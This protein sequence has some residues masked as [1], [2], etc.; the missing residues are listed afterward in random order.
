MKSPDIQQS[1]FLLAV[2]FT[3]ASYAADKCG[4]FNLIE[5][6]P[7]NETWLNPGFYSYHF[8]YDKNL[9]NNNPGLGVEYRYSTVSSVTAGRFHNSDWQISNYA[10]WYWQPFR[11]GSMR[12]GALLGA[13]D[14]YP[15]TRDGD[16]FLMALPIA[17]YEYKNIGINLTVVPTIKDTVYGSLTLQLKLK[18]H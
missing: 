10:A 6:K 14:G 13:M 18:L 9:N 5:A 3:P 1:L 7:I 8:D 2:A 17:S 4:P 15:R 11:L 12:I 16:W